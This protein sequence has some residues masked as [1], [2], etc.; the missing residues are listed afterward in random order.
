MHRLPRR[1]V[2]AVGLTLAAS[3]SAAACSADTNSSDGPTTPDGYTLTEVPDFGFS[4][5]VP[6]DWTTL[7]H[8]DLDD[9]ELVA[10]V[11]EALGQ[12]AD[13]LRDTADTFHLISVDA[14]AT[15]YAENLA[16]SQYELE[17]GLPP[18]EELAEVTD[19]DQVS[20]SDHAQR[21]TGSGADAVLYT[22]SGTLSGSGEAF[23]IA[24]MAVSM[25]T[26]ATAS[27]DAATAPSTATF[28]MIRA[29]SADRAQELADV[30][31][32]SV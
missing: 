29:A 27:A 14:N 23:H 10:T 19:D 31:L 24:F 3:L 4:L 18:A 32:G 17:D 13:S 20:S 11:A 25:D 16:V 28:V 12:D 26:G 8:D 7:T 2:L 6:T 5:A 22:A 15:G 9:D 21:I 30:V 1:T